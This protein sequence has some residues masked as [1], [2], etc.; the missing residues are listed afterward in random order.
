MK[1]LVIQGSPRGAHGNTEVLVQAFIQGAREAG[2]DIM[3]P[4]YLKEKDI[5][6]CIGCFS[7]WTRTP[8]VCVHHDDMPG[9]LLKVREADML[10][11]ATPLYY[12]TVS[13]FMKDFLDRTLPLSQPFL[14]VEGDCCG[15]PPRY[16][17]GLW[18][19]VVIS[20]CGFPE[21]AHFSGLKETFRVMLHGDKS[22]LKGMICCAGGELLKVKELR[23]G[24]AWYLDAVKK[25]GAEVVKEGKVSEGTSAV[26]DRP[27]MEDHNLYAS[28]ANEHWRSLGVK[29]QEVD[30]QGAPDEQGAPEGKPL[31]PPGKVE[32]MGDLVAAMAAAFNPKAAGSLK[33]AVQFVVTD[34]KPG[35]YY[36]VIESGRCSAWQGKHQKPS[37]TVTT[38]APVWLGI[39]RGETNGATAFLSG[40]YKVAGDVG[41][42]MKFNALFPHAPR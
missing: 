10:V 36:L 29:L 38:P 18:N 3:E 2:A 24:L 13:G 7:C 37:A 25:A 19:L 23:D 41:L 15:H 34:E 14:E 12:Y 20:N 39:Y 8:G 1:L 5:K 31:P 22:E 17:S 32:T 6:H 27:L 35:E 26:L 4:V 16:T 33:A 30:A 11:L 40:K 42:L 21:Q 28:L 9:L